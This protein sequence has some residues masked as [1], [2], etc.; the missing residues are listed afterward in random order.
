MRSTPEVDKIDR[1]C[2]HVDAMTKKGEVTFTEECKRLLDIC[3]KIGTKGDKKHA[4][5]EAKACLKHKYSWVH[6]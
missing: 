6:K 4:K 3:D 2:M 1:K 5:H